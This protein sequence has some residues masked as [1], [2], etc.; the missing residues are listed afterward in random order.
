[1]LPRLHLPSLRVSVVP[2]HTE[3]FVRVGVGGLGVYEEK[4]GGRGF[5]RART[6]SP[7]L[8]FSS[9]PSACPLVFAPSGVF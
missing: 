1:M 7:L 9:T 5:S 6:A 3:L 4:D 8:T 2:L